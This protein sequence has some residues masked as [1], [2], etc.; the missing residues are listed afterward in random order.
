MAIEVPL[1]SWSSNTGKFLVEKVLAFQ[2]S[3]IYLNDDNE[4][5]SVYHLLYKELH[6]IL[7]VVNCVA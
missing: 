2:S 3:F 6:R 1:N 5:V 7:Q 4:E